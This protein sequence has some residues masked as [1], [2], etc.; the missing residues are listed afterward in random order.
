MI[1][2]AA[3]TLLFGKKCDENGINLLSIEQEL[4][5][6]LAF[7]NHSRRPHY[8]QHRFVRRHGSRGYFTHRC[9]A[10][11]KVARAPPCLKTVSLPTNIRISDYDRE[12][13]DTVKHVHRSRD[14]ANMAQSRI[15]CDDCPKIVWPLGKGVRIGTAGIQC[16]T[17]MALLAVSHG[18]GVIEPADIS[19]RKKAIV[20]WTKLK[21]F[22]GEDPTR[23]HGERSTRVRGRAPR[24]VNYS[25]NSNGYAVFKQGILGKQITQF[26]ETEY[27][28]RRD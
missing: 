25:R 19:I 20:E 21:A 14:I 13:G 11:K 12:V 27:V 9:L 10:E 2:S 17:S 15:V 23:C 5:P 6:S 1:I 24:F 8:A 3:T 22:C 28:R 26:F 7:F 16:M 4:A 18:L